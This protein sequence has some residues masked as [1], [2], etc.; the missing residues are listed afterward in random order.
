MRHSFAG[1]LILT[2]AAL[3]PTPGLL[4]QTR[5]PPAPDTPTFK[6]GVDVVTVEVG[7]SD[8]RGQPVRTLTASDFIVKVDGKPRRIVS[9]RHVRFDVEE[10]RKQAAAARDVETY[11]TTNIGP[12]G[13]RLIMLAVDQT[14]IRPGAVRQLLNTAAAFL[15]H[16][17][18][19]DQVAF[20]AYPPPGPEIGFTTDRLRIK[21][22]MAQVVGN[23]QP[24]QG[25]FNLGIS[26]SIA[27][28]E[29]RDDIALRAAVMRECGVQVRPQG[30]G[31]QGQQG[32][33]GQMGQD[34][35]PR[36][37]AADA[38]AR[39]QHARNEARISLQ[40]L[41]SLLQRLTY[42]HGQKS[43]ILLSEGLVV[44]DAA[45][46]LE[47]VARLAAMSRTSLNVMVMDVPR[48]DLTQAQLAP[49]LSQD[50]A[51]EVR[52]LEDMA[53]LARGTVVQV[54]GTGKTAFDR[55]LGELSGYYEL[56]V[57]EAPSD[58]QGDANTRRRLDISVRRKGLVLRSHEAFVLSS[59]VRG[60]RSPEDSLFDALN[61][62]F[63]VAEIPMRVTSF[64]FQEPADAD[65]V[66]LILPV[67]VG[68]AGVPPGDYRV[69]YVL[70][71]ELGR[72]VSSHQ[73]KTRLAPVDGRED[74]PLAYVVSVI[75]DPGSYVLRI[76]A[77]DDQGRRAS[78]VRD[79]HAYKFSG[80][81]LAAGDLLLGNTPAAADTPIHPQVEPRIYGNQLRAYVELY[82]AQPVVFDGAAVSM[83]IAEDEDAAPLAVVPLPL[84]PGARQSARVAEGAINTDVLP[85]GRYVARVKIARDG[86]PAGALARPF[87]LTPSSAAAKAYMPAHLVTWI[88]A[89]DREAML[90]T[91][92][93]APMLDLLQRSSA[94]LGDAMTEARAG[95]YGAAALEALTAGDQTSA[96][97]LRGLDFLTKGQLDQA[98]TQFNNA[99]G[100]RREFFPAAFYLGVCYAAA[101]NDR[102]AAGVWQL[103]LLGDPKPGPAYS[104]F[105]DA[106]L[107][108]MQPSSVIDVLA[109]VVPQLPENDA[110]L[111]RLAIAYLMTGRYAE[112]TPVLDDFLARHATDQ[113]ALFAAVVAQYQESAKANVPLSNVV[114]AKLTKYERAYKGPDKALLTR[115]LA[116]L[117]A[118]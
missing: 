51:L 65:K 33:Q 73:E 3:S 116:S 1:L 24:F 75:A 2:A 20:A 45:R 25:R 86:K 15:D 110:L 93:V 34:S 107:R 38:A 106:R 39:A 99:A 89:F 90:K 11:F 92:I 44:D 41:R 71:D 103:A 9:A 76:G 18:P 29:R 27:I 100:A 66:R 47:D 95:R 70:F 85:P 72:I 118:K 58:R 46:E 98:A 35:C 115:Y 113:E 14:N 55:L 31:Q 91:A 40:G 10:A 68:Q 77:V 94:S 104:L 81:E 12:P 79:V 50:R 49:T 21:R 52:G 56:G 48:I 54:I 111:K 19:L 74:V 4:A 117:D 13:G 102:D 101:G 26:E 112:A 114:R 30:R 78:V 23:Q 36:D 7:V 108:T 17:G 62:P 53:A 88:P 87:V 6:T 83:E 28:H 5:V 64:A 61:S 22:A 60:A 97:F 16:L 63:S 96:M 42:I 43:L 109:R 69:G 67:E 105:A 80:Q 37:V 32:Q 82:A 84:S 8:N 59:A 57:E